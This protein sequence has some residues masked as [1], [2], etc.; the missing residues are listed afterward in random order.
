MV[1]NTCDSSDYIETSLY[2]GTG[3][4]SINFIYPLYGLHF[5]SLYNDSVI[6]SIIKDDSETSVNFRL[7]YTY[8]NVKDLMN[9]V[10]GHSEKKNVI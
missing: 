9:S 1:A 6:I 8:V 4:I 7:E 5:L 10:I 2:K 3:I